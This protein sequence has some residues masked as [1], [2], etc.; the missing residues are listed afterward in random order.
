M[1]DE[2]FYEQIYAILTVAYGDN[3]FNNIV[4]D[5]L[6]HEI[7]S[8]LVDNMCINKYV[9]VAQ[10]IAR[11]YGVYES[12]GYAIDSVFFSVGKAHEIPTKVD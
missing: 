9:K 2:I 8:I 1:S 11:T 5:T 4:N 10:T 6:A 7:N 12:T 3:D